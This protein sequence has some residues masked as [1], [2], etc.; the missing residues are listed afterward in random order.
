MKMRNEFTCCDRCFE[1]LQ[2]R[3]AKAAK[4]WM[5]LCQSYMEIP[6]LFSVE[7][8]SP[9]IR[10]LETLG[11]ITTTDCSDDVYSDYIILRVNGHRKD[12]YGEDCFCISK[13]GR[14]A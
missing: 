11:F 5:N 6:G 7:G 3:S 10:I 4:I 8:N 13:D 12:F 1:T 9:Q 14:H 2:K